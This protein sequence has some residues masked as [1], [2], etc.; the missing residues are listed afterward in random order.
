[1]TTRRLLPAIQR[2]ILV[3]MSEVTRILAAIEQGDPSAAEHLLPLD[4]ELRKLAAQRLAN[5]KP[6]QTLQPTAWTRGL[7]PV[8][9]R[10]PRSA[11][12]RARPISSPPPPRPAPHPRRA[13]PAQAT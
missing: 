10:E 6:V 13:G 5:E 4:D 2:C 9:P 7:R 1:M 3:L 11:L 12:E 8:G